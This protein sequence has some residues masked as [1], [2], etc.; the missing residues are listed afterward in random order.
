MKIV[1]I[2]PRKTNNERLPGKNTKILGDV[3]LITYVQKLVLGLNM[4][5]E[6]YVFCSDESIKSYLLPGIRFCSVTQA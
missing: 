5:S 6:R 4:I 1:S 3:P 2:I